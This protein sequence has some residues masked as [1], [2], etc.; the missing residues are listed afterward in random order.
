MAYYLFLNAAGHVLGSETP[1]T[2]PLE[3]RAR[4]HNVALTM[5]LNEVLG[6]KRLRREA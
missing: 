6:R 5:A 2:V 3:Q 1:V 4:A